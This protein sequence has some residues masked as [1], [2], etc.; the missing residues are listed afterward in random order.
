MSELPKSDPAIAR[1]RR[2]GSRHALGLGVVILMLVLAL[3]SAPARAQSRPLPATL[4]GVTL[5]NTA[6]IHGDTLNN[7]VAGLGALPTLPVA[8]V[9]MDVG[10]KP[11]AYAT[12]VNAL[13]PVSYLMAELGDSSEMKHQSVAGYQRFESALVAAYANT[14][15]LWEVGNE[16]NG[17]WVGSTAKEVAK[18]TDAYN[19]VTAVGG[20]TAL[21]LYYNPDCWSKRSHEMFTWAQAH[22]PAA[23]KAG[24]D[25]VLIS[26]YPNDCNNYW[27]TQAG[28]QSVFDQLHAMFPSA[29]LGF[30]ES[31]ISTD[32]GTPAVKAALLAKYYDLHIT[33]D[34]YSGGYFWWYF[35]EDALP[36]QGNAVWNA[37][38]SAMV[39]PSA[40]PASPR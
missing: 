36:Y 21:T 1:F 3:G 33:G 2:Y 7:E 35:A 5:D 14:V 4:W 39:A 12:A 37:L 22:I 38:Q 11:A 32:N 16:V 31:G 10:T 20:A 9:V 17:E 26:Y 24:L 27:P 6:D 13:H 30:G 34:D 40:L 29:R 15:D 19:S 18:I 23:M 28:W 25:D 8:R